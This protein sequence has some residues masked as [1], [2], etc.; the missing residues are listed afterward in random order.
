MNNGIFGLTYPAS[1]QHFSIREQQIY[2]IRT[3]LPTKLSTYDEYMTDLV[4]RLTEIQRLAHE[5]LLKAKLKS[6][7]YYDKKLHPQEFKVGTFVYLCSGPKPGK[8][9]DHN[10][11]PLRVLQ[12][13]KNHNVKIKY[14]NS[15]KIVHS[16]RLKLAHIL[17]KT[18][19]HVIYLSVS[20][21]K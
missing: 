13:S 11:G 4:E 2:T 14:K 19:A 8:L 18:T 7:Y 5:N 21:R 3:K 6:K 17:P 20:D 15:S 12:V 1:V 9:F 16:N 10:S